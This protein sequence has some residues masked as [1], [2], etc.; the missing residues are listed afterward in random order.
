VNKKKDEYYNVPIS[1]VALI[2]LELREA[3]RTVPLAQARSL[4]N[5]DVHHYSF[6]AVDWMHFLPCSGE[7]LLAG[8]VSG[9]YYNMLMASCRAGR[10][11]F[12]PR[13]VTKADIQSI[14]EDIKYFVTKYYV[15]IYRGKAHRLPLCLSTSATQLGILPLLWACRPAWM[16]W[17]FPMESKIGSLGRLMRSVSRPHESVVATVT[18]HIKAD[19]VSY[20]AEKFFLE[21]LAR[22][23]DKKQATVGLPVG[24]LLAS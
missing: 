5:I 3:R 17:Q 12:R 8:R 14:D 24:C 21:D 1:T 18:R 20:F 23:T 10:L 16:V 15:K 7:V 2:C 13:V 4:R 11:L 19:F 6:K 9:D 22:A